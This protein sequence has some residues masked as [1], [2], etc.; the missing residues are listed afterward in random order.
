VEACSKKKNLTRRFF[1]R[2]HT[3]KGVATE[4]VLSTTTKEKEEKYWGKAG[5]TKAGGR[6]EK[7]AVTRGGRIRGADESLQTSR[8][9]KTTKIRSVDNKPL[10]G[11]VG[12]KK[13]SSGG[14]KEF[15]KGKWILP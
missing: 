14:K 7:A 6:K 9:R 2:G 13:R 5:G 11:K 3:K 4:K 15:G 8:G 1:V 10:R 12:E